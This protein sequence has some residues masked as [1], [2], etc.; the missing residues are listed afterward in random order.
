MPYLGRE[1]T[2]GTYLKLDSIQSQFN[3][4]LTTFNLK[5]GGSD[6][7]PGSSYSLMV[8]L[9]G[10]V[11]EAESAYEINNNQIVF[12]T[13]PAGGAACFI[14][15]LG[16]A[17]GVGVPGDG[18]V[19][20]AQLASNSVGLD[21][22]QDSAKLDVRKNGT[23]VGSAVTE[24]DFKGTGISTTQY[25]TTAGIATIY[26]DQGS[27]LG[28]TTS[29]GLG[30]GTTIST[31]N[32]QTINFAG[33][34]VTTGYYNSG[35]GIATIFFEGG[36]SVGAAGTWKSDEV[37]VATSKV[38]GVGTAQ[39]VGTANSEG[40]L[41]AYGNVAIIDGVLA[42]DQVLD[43][44]VFVPTGRN[45]LLVGPVTVGAGITLDV[46]TGSTLVVV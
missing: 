19:G 6:F 8:S 5:S 9:A 46:A 34:G 2:S 30:A 38:V 16:L 10:V 18:T 12:T 40:A 4:S 23:L 45:G 37:G 29:I 20:N 39:A 35:V 43:T 33:P 17:L 41:Q 42:T 14:I 21:N 25:N 36:G 44:N 15:V 22:L 13:A 1:L 7:Y 32:L 31:V 11:Q 28:V 26:V 24:I 27:S 3:G